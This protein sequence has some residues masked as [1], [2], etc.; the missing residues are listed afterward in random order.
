MGFYGGSKSD[1]EHADA[2]HW[3]KVLEAA[4]R[5]KVYC[6]QRLKSKAERSHHA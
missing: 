4:R 3:R 6:N 1:G 2:P 5:L